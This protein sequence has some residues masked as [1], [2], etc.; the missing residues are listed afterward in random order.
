MGG[1]NS[2]V[3]SLS[4]VCAR[5]QRYTSTTLRRPQALL[6]LPFDCTASVVNTSRYNVI[7]PELTELNKARILAAF[8]V[9]F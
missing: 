3:H 4:S 7:S 6:A 5:Y 1:W 8:Q 9:V 2:N